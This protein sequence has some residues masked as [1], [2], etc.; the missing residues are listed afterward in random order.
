MLTKDGIDTTQAYFN[1]ATQSMLTKKHFIKAAEYV[2]K[3]PEGKLKREL[4]KCLASVFCA[5]NPNFDHWRFFI[6]C[7]L[8][9]KPNKKRNKK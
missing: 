8:I 3:I 9:K 7:G 1:K 4:S 2:A 5:D 6:A